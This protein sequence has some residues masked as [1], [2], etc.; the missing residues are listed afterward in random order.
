M[1][2]EDTEETEEKKKYRWRGISFHAII[3]MKFGLSASGF[4]IQAQFCERSDPFFQ[5]LDY[6]SCALTN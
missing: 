4:L 6:E 1:N 5:K 3:D 2:G